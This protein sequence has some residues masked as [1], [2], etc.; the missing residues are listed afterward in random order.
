MLTPDELV[1]LYA[2]YQLDELRQAVALG[3]LDYS[4][5]AWIALCAECER[6]G[7]P[8]VPSGIV[9]PVSMLSAQE[10]GS[11]AVKRCREAA[12][13]C[14]VV[15]GLLVC[16]AG[17]LIVRE[18]D[19]LSREFMIW[20]IFVVI[21]GSLGFIVK[22]IYEGNQAALWAMGLVVASILWL[23]GMDLVDKPVAANGQFYLIAVLV[24]LAMEIT[25]VRAIVAVRR[26]A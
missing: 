26:D 12:I 18:W 3:P 1:R 16:A 23:V 25:I 19:F 22:K 8:W 2:G 20:V 17:Y 21:F 24:P 10:M 4:R 9:P 7:I 5:D 15:V 11:H 13:V 6:R 14:G